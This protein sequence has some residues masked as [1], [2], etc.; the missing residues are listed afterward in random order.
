ML[1]RSDGKIQKATPGE[2]SPVDEN[3]LN[4]SMRQEP[5]QQPQ[6]REP[7]QQPLQQPQPQY[8]E[9][10]EQP[11]RQPMEVQQP[12]PELQ[13]F[14]YQE[15]RQ[16]NPFVGMQQEPRFVDI[17]LVVET[18]GS[19]VIPVEENQV[20]NFLSKIAEAI[21]NQSTLEVGNQF[22]NGRYIISYNI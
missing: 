18:V 13:H 8:R 21:D 22:V 1:F 9:P 3:V 16:H 2:P 14:Q 20:R 10:I 7:I 6:Y 12:R 17:T 15:Q 19:V 4:K 5:V 11:L